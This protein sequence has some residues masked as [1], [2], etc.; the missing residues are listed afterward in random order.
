MS[1]QVDLKFIHLLS[2]RFE[3]FVRKHDYLFNCRC[4]LCGDSQKNKSKMRGYLFRKG[5]EMF[6]RCH[7]CGAS[8]G[9]GN[10]IKQLDIGLFREYLL[11]RYKNGETGNKQ[12]K[13]KTFNIPSPKFDKVDDVLI[14]ENAERCDKLSEG[15][16]C[17]EYLKSRNIPLDKYKL[18]WYTDN[19]KKFADEIY[20]EH[21][22]IISEDKRLIIPFF[23]KYNSLIAISGRALEFTKERLRYVTVRTN[24]SDDK[25]IYGSD[26]IILSQKIYIV[27]GPIDSLFLNNSLASGD[28]NLALVAKQLIESGVP[29]DQIVLVPDREPRNKEIVNLI[30]KFIQDGYN[31]CLL[32]NTLKGKDINEHILNGF[33]PEDVHKIIDKNTFSGLKLKMEFVQWKKTS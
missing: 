5:N 12:F 21:E 9:L 23:D 22:K 10:F 33:S 31:I 27:E 11:E 19:Y 28:S 20:P 7:N 29:K 25:L 13:E 18:L 17:L 1:L 4:P 24:N 32:P 6:Y 8:L 3:K 26:R 2:P 14:Y 30:N 16:F 15:H